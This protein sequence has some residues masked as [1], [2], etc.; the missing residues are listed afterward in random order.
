MTIIELAH[1][2]G[3]KPRW[4]AGTQGGEYHSACPICG[5]KDRFYIQPK[6]QMRKCFGSYRCR[7]CGIYGDAIQFAID[8]LGMSFVEATQ[9]LEIDLDMALPVQK[10]ASNCVLQQP[11]NLWLQRSKNLVINAHNA[12]LGK[13]DV[14]AY[15]EKRGLPLP[16]IE[17]H[18]LG[19][20]DKDIR[21]DREAWGLEKRVDDAG[22]KSIL[23]IPQ[24]LLIPN[25][26]NSGNVVRLK[27]RR[28]AW[29]EKDALP[30]YVAVSGSMNG[31]SI[32]GSRKNNVIIV[33]ESELDALA[34]DH[35]VHDIATTIAVG[36]NLK[37]P[38]NVTDHLV[39]AAK[40][41]LICYDNDTAGEKMF[42]K[43]KN[44]YPHSMR[45]ATPIGKDV[46]E[47]IQQGL[48][49]HDWLV[50]VINQSDIFQKIA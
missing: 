27:V 26:E 28:S 34:V 49:L 11:P 5:G 43:W 48:V 24:G 18:M 32:I 40:R 14:L 16:A 8:I 37:N 31:L 35:A 39:R 6:K 47:A 33:V 36:S 3:I 17:R 23:W 2:A 45:Y 21:V 25:I 38:D 13:I 42:D 12:L 1:Q 22:K 15:L 44:L 19:W 7:Q 20:I 29:H 30:K 50:K 10:N 46:G 9:Y 4:V 41:L